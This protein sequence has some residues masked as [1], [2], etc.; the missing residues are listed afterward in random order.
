[1]TD[2]QIHELNLI[3][4]RITTLKVLSQTAA[5]ALNEVRFNQLTNIISP[6]DLAVITAA[7]D[8]LNK[9]ASNSTERDAIK[10]FKELQK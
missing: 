4:S 5:N 9:I 2:K 3:S 8:I 6:E 7:M 1:M 10:L